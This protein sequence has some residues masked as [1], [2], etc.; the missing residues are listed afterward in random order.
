MENKVINISNVVQV[1]KALAELKEQMVFVGGAVISLYA[2]DPSADEIRPTADIDMT[3]K[4]LNYSE[5][6]KLNQ[7]LAEL[8]I[9]PDPN[10]H[11]I[12]SYL[13]KDIPLDIMP[14]EDGPLGPS[15]SW[16]KIGFEDLQYINVEGEK[17]Q[18]FTAPCFLATK[19][20]AYHQREAVPD[21]RL[22]HDFEDIIYVID[23][24]ISIVDEIIKAPKLLKDFLKTEFQKIIVHPHEEEILSAHLH[25][26]ILEERYPIILDKIKQI[27]NS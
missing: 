21:Y 12:C 2:D 4:L 3:I 9:Y 19:F 26:I 20:E 27:I 1:A 25:P 16:Y 5:L 23:N 10:G 17:I 13:Y 24:R 11:A 22:S 15:N 7:R 6:V 14:S 8:N 18:L